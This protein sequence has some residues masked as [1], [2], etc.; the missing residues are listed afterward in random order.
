[1]YFSFSS[2]RCFTLIVLLFGQGVDLSCLSKSLM[3]RSI[4]AMMPWLSSD[5]YVGNHEHDL[6]H[7]FLICL[8]IQGNLR[9]QH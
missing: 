6:G 2:L 9:E 8:G 3:K 5:L 1:M 7:A 4:M